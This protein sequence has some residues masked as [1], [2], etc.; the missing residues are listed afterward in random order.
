MKY[1]SRCRWLRGVE[2][3]KSG[4]RPPADVRKSD[5]ALDGGQARRGIGAARRRSMFRAVVA[6]YNRF[7]IWTNVSRSL[8]NVDHAA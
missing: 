3:E 8:R 7:V 4:S 2:V 1:R 5:P 6:V